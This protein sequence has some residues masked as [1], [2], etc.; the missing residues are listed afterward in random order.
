[1]EL[2]WGADFMYDLV[3]LSKGKMSMYISDMAWMES[4]TLYIL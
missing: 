4:L 1:M 2:L 3:N